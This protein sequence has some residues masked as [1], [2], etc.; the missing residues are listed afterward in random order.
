MESIFKLYSIGYVAENK[1]RTDRF[2]NVLP[3]EDAGAT[4]GEITFKPQTEII[5]GQDSN[6]KLYDVTITSDVTINCE[7][8]PEGTNRFTPPDVVRGELVEIYRLGDT[9]QYYWR[10]MGLRDNLRTLET[11]IFAFSATPSFAGE[12]L[13]LNRCYFLEV[14][15]HDKLVTFRTSKANGEPFVY[16]AQFNTKEGWFAM[17]DDIG[18]QFEMVSK[19]RILKMINADSSFL[20]I[21]KKIITMKA[22]Q[23]IKFICGGST[24]TMT[25]GEI[26]SKTNR[27]FVDGGGTTWEQ[28]GAGVT[29]TTPAFDIV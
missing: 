18:N 27:W 10:C 14:S 26:N 1:P 9:K 28:I 24:M 13:D 3:V 29:V 16:T 7:W 12:V 15:T 4:D 8:L 19:E 22:D 20:D 23:M 11:V 5:K 17:C 6:G 25:P 2:V 21:N